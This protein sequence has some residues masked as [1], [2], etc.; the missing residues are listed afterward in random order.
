LNATKE[1]ADRSSTLQEKF[2]REHKS[3]LKDEWSGA[4]IKLK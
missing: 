4:Y 2:V 3:D 1:Q